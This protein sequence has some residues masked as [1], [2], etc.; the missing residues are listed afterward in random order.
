[1]DRK[2]STHREKRNAYRILV[3]KPEGKSPLGRPRCKGWIIRVL[4]RILERQDWVVWTGL[5][6]L[7]IGTSGG[8]GL[9]NTV[10]NIWV[11]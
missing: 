10:M 8:D 4:R 9:V 7:R 3:R 2:C 11:P 5:I 6:W 1:M